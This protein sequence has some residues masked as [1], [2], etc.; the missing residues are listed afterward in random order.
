MTRQEI[1]NMMRDLPSQR[2]WYYRRSRQYIIEEVLAG[3][4]FVTC[5]GIL[6]LM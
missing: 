1:D 5:V 6:C 4:A 3:V 2:D